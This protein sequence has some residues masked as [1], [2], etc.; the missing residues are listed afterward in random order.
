MRIIAGELKGRRLKAPKGTT[1]RP[2]VDRV[3]ESLMSTILSARGSWDGACVLDVFAG[4]GALG[5]EAL[6]R[7]AAFA[8]FCERDAQA[9]SALRENV[10]VA[11]S[12]RVRTVRMDVMRRMPPRAE[13]AGYDLVF[14]DPPYVMKASEVAK[15]MARMLEVGIMVSGALVS[16]EHASTLDLHDD[17]DFS[18]LA[19]DHVATK[20]FGETTIDVLKIGNA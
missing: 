17:P 18:S 9:F 3:R 2:T 19:C 1:T 8:C 12:D 10:S 20:K 5:L 13:G 7:G 16:Y 11:P 15:L 14:L 4:S 6:S